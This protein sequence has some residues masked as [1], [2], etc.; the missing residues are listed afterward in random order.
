MGDQVGK[1]YSHSNWIWSRLCEMNVVPTD[2]VPL[3]RFVAG[4]LPIR[5]D[6]PLHLL[7]TGLAAIKGPED[8]ALE[9]GLVV[10]GG[11]VLLDCHPL[12][13]DGAGKGID[14]GAHQALE[15]TGFLL[16]LGR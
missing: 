12:V 13:E 11:P 9:V 2:G 4:D 1:I 5:L 7:C 10:D 16:L 8:S 6:P 14:C 15:P 3:P